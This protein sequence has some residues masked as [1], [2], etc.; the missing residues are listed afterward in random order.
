MYCEIESVGAQRM[1][2]RRDRAFKWLIAAAVVVC[3]MALCMIFW[4][5][6][7]ALQATDARRPI[8]QAQL[9]DMQIVCSH[10]DNRDCMNA[11]ANMCRST[12]NGRTVYSSES[13]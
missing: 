9:L 8:T 3:V 11:R 2:E 7:G 6:S 13:C 4:Y 1:R 5:V 12:I 10:V